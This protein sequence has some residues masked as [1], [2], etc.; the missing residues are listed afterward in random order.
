MSL[1]PRFF[2]RHSQPRTSALG[3]RIPFW[4]DP[5]DPPDAADEKF[6]SKNY[7]PR[8]YSWV[9]SPSEVN[10]NSPEDTQPGKIFVGRK[11]TAPDFEMYSHQEETRSGMIIVEKETIA[12]A[13]KLHSHKINEI[14]DI[15]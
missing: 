3:T 14:I 12:P 5:P 13:S 8:K 15:F 1:L 2:K 11:M 6:S 4:K 10:E 9:L 7:P